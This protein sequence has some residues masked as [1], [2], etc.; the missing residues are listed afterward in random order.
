[1]TPSHSGMMPRVDQARF[2]LTGPDASGS[3]PAMANDLHLQTATVDGRTVAYAEAG[4]PRGVPV[5]HLHGAGLSR[6]EVLMFDA[7]ACAAGVR[8]IGPDRPGCGYSEPSPKFTLVQYADD[9]AGLADT[10]GI[11][12]FVV[13]GV[14]SGGTYAMAAASALPDR[15]AGV[16]PINSATPTSDPAVRKHVSG[17]GRIAYFA[18]KKAPWLI[19]AMTRAFSPRPPDDETGDKPVKLPI[20]ARLAF[21]DLAMAEL[22]AR[23]QAES[24]RQPDSG[25]LNNELRLVTAPWGFDH[26]A[27]TPPV[28]M[29]SSDK[30]SGYRYAQVWTSNL[31][32]AALHVFPGHHGAFVLPPTPARI[33]GAMAALAAL[34]SISPVA[35][36]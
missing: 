25:Y 18:A 36:G 27:V 31:P 13:S 3:M 10:L 16:V 20:G 22:F 19:N 15:V 4:D 12:R 28:A 14:S 6:L 34:G 11:D 5:L 8:L 30:D 21:P 33:V 29:F 17:S 1:M 23:A 24:W 2:R 26:T 9:L 32:E 35:S 7:E